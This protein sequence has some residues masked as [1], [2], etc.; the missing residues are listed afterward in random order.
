MRKI[1]Y[2]LFLLPFSCAY[3]TTVSPART[4]YIQLNRKIDIDAE[5]YYFEI[6]NGE[7]EMVDELSQIHKVSFYESNGGKTN[8]MGYDIKEVSNGDKI[9]RLYLYKWEN[10]FD[11]IE[12]LSLSY[13]EIEKNENYKLDTILVY[14]IVA[15]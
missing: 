3:I 15:D 12:L 4:Y 8:F 1:I 7:I 11:R 9:D 14:K 13:E 6:V 5:K 2:L 10:G